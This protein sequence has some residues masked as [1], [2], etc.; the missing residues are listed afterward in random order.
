VSDS[1]TL[2]R[3]AMAAMEQSKPLMRITEP[4]A[5]TIARR[6]YF[7]AWPM[8]N[9]FNRRL[10]FD[11]APEPGLMNGVL[12]LAPL[13]TLSM[14]HN[15][16]EPD[17][18]WV[19]CPNQDVVYGA[20]IAALDRSPVIVQVP[21]FGSRFWVYQVVD[22][23]TDSFA[24]LGAMYGTR[25]GFYMLVGPDWQGERPNGVAEVFRAGSNTAMVVP[26][27]FQ[28]DTAQ[29]RD[30]IQEVIS[31][32]DLY[33]L[34]KLD[35]TM[36]RRDW[37]KLPKFMQGGGESGEETKWVFPETFFDQLPVV[38]A[39]A[40]PLPGEEAIYREALSIVEAAKADP[41]LKAALIDEVGKTDREVI[42][43]LLQFRQL[44]RPHGQLLD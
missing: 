18:R 40:R 42:G 21:D 7:W 43:P 37:A 20:G 5:R 19:A 17:Q 13:N 32:V 35:G 9:I 26:R 11:K 14:L 31:Q 3:A 24:Q 10:A 4:Y 23:R 44:G 25:P 22:L 33:A 27:I 12:P 6:T 1:E 8:V 2:E 29:D 39:D 16:V 30:A 34:D 36:R 28:D 41:T 15:Y 38:L